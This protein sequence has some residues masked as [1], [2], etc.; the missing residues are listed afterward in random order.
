MI[1][2][3]GYSGKS[4]DDLRA[5]AERLNAVVVDIR[6][7][8]QSRWQPKWNKSSLSIL[9]EDR[10]IWVGEL[11]NVKYKEKQIEIKD[12]D[13]G[14]EKVLA[15]ERD[16]ILLCSCSEYENCHRKTVADAL[17]ERGREVEELDTWQ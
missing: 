11:G 12:L 6:L 3:T 14:L 13:A 15:I 9:L 1:Y 7:R 8:P 4:V 10:Y 16:V 17:R 5:L 2:T